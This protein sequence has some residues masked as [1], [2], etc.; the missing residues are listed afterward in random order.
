MC[1]LNI[2]GVS[3]E[4]NRADIEGGAIKWNYIEPEIINCQFVNNSAG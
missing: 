1:Q 3:F 4:N 2:E